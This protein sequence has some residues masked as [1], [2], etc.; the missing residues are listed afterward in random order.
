VVDQYDR[1]LASSE[2]DH[3]LGPGEHPD[4]YEPLLAQHK[5]AVGLT[6]PVAM[7]DPTDQSQRHV[8][9]F[10]PLHSVP[11]GL[12]L[13]GSEAELAADTNRWEHQIA[14]FGGVTLLLALGLVWLTT[15]GVARPIEA[16]TTASR[17]IAGGDLDT[18]IPHEGEGEVRVLA[19]AFDEMRNDLQGR[20]RRWPWRRAATRGLSARW[21]MSCSRR[22]WTC[23]SPRST[24]L[25]QR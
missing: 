8:M 4:I 16:L 13:G 23:A 14:L 12:A 21:L 15:G 20:C 1:V 2:P 24:P 9:A 19:Q 22:T 6:A 7:T 17:R 5:S 11:W 10:V 3:V 18:P 25:P